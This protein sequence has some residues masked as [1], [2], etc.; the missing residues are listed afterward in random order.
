MKV[1]S[2]SKLNPGNFEG[3]V[4][5]GVR[6]NFGSNVGAEVTGPRPTRKQPKASLKAAENTQQQKDGLL[7]AK[8]KT[9]V[10]GKEREKA[11]PKRRKLG[12]KALQARLEMSQLLDTYTPPPSN[13]VILNS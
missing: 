11:A 2:M 6:R 7:G 4:G 9:K 10:K 5:G 3:D 1:S 8:A 13:S 12:K